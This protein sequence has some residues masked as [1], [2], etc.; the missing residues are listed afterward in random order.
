MQAQQ[1]EMQQHGETMEEMEESGPQ[2][3]E[4]LE[5]HGVSATDIKKLKDANM[6]T[7]ESVR[8]FLP[9]SPLASPISCFVLVECGFVHPLM[10][11]NLRLY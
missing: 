1:E 10:L 6:F 11:V 8:F 4:T 9:P 3:V 7:V 2:M 5:S